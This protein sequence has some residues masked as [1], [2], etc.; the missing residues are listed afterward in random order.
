M[1]KLLLIFGLSV[2]AFWAFGQFIGNGPYPPPPSAGGGGSVSNYNQANPLQFNALTVTN[3]LTNSSTTSP[4]QSAAGFIAAGG[5]PGLS[6]SNTMGANGDYVLAQTNGIVVAGQQQFTTNYAVAWTPVIDMSKVES[7]IVSSTN[8]S[9]SVAN[10]PT[11][12]LAYHSM[13]ISNSGANASTIVVTLVGFCAITNAGAPTSTFYV[14]NLIAKNQVAELDVRCR[15]T[16]RTNA[17]V[18]HFYDK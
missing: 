14:T 16:I 17:I 12:L 2:L 11:S 18:S 3:G 7:V 5:S 1:K 10:I 4:I 15:A 9:L 8:F 13:T 6:I